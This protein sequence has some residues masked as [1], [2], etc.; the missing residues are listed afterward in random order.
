MSTAAVTTQFRLRRPLRSLVPRNPTHKRM[1]REAAACP[2]LKE[3]AP[4]EAV[5]LQHLGQVRM[6]A[7]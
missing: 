4:Y 7:K 3:P 2:A 1:R 6:I 5:I